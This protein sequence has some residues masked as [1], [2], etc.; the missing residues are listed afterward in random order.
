MSINM[1]VEENN[2]YTIAPPSASAMLESLRAY[3]YSL[4]SA[5]SDLIDN[6]ITAKAQN[7]WIHLH[8][9]GPNSWITIRD[10]GL[11]MTD[12][13]LSEAMV[14]GS[15][16]PLL[17]R[18]K[19]DLGR[20]GLGL[21]TASLSLARS[22]TVASKQASSSLSI[23]RWDLDYIASLEK[24]NWI[25]LKYPRGGAEE[26]LATLD[27]QDS[28]TLILLENLD[29]LCGGTNVASQAHQ[30][31]FYHRIDSLRNHLGMIF[32]RYLSSSK[33]LNIYI[34]G[35]KPVHAV[36]AW[37]PFCKSHNATD[38]KPSLDIPYDG[39]YVNIQGFILPH[40]DM[41]TSDELEQAAGPNG[42][43]AQQGFYVYRNDRLLVAG[44]WLG[45][46][47]S[48]SRWKSEEHYKLAR[49]KVDISNDMDADWQIDV[50]KSVAIPPH[51]VS[52]V[53]TSYASTI[54][55]EARQI[56]AHR[57]RYGKRTKSERVSKIWVTKERKGFNAYQV[58][59][60]HPIVSNFLNKLSLEAKTEAKLL[61]K[62]I[63]ETVPVEQIWLDASET[64][65]KRNTPF[66]TASE[67][68]VIQAAERTV[69]M[70]SGSDTP[71]S[72]IVEQVCQLECFIDYQDIIFA[73]FGV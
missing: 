15:Q 22:L 19:D 26:K 60:K 71:A 17:E 68:E 41:M 10:D 1:E 11:G 45:L 23:R 32:H 59:R 13:I 28:G 62:L 61:L 49:I 50:K 70:I 56:F 2:S 64:P 53:L 7:I 46:R 29:K 48:S 69:K 42:W 34:N 39:K 36:P 51:T 18:A 54:R 5:I 52:R 24:D 21:K 20:F 47:D 66:N 6:S 65:E 63:E 33:K 31:D 25:L 12:S 58:D 73:H 38:I 67:L 44:S 4:N 16:N 14:A 8:W 30:D 40:K 27:A 72:D 37:D 9:D 55:K 43:N 57:G 35:T 3:G